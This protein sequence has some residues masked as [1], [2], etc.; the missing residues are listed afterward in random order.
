MA[1]AL[2]P[3]HIKTR[4]LIISDTHGT[5]PKPRDGPS[6]DDELNK[7]DVAR[8]VTGWRDPL[9]E[10]DVV[11]HCGDLT[12]R[13]TIPEFEATFSVLQSIKAPLKLAIAGNHDTA[14]DH[15][16]WIN[17][18]GGSKETLDNVETIIRKAEKDGV[19]YLTEGVHQF[20]MANGALLK[21]YASPWTP[22]Y[23]GWAFQY[24]NGHDFDIPPG[25]DVVLTHGPPQGIRDF[26]GVA[27]THAG[28]PDLLAA[29]AH[30]KPKI[31][32]FGH[33]HEAWGMHYVTWDG[34]KI[35][36]D[37]SRQVGLKGLRP[38]KVTQDDEMAKI[39]RAKLIE[40]SKQR[41]AYL[42]LTQEDSCIIPGEQT[43]FVNAAIMDIRYRPIQ[44]PWLIDVNLAPQGQ[45]N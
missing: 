29:V 17:K 19:K 2:G 31:H 27:G 30:A 3:K 21:V 45:K 26:A 10:V 35:N 38:G 14:L 18:F 15:D 36:E 9:P 41:G 23:G 1:E 28:C 11:I 13:T 22:A 12:K 43:L 40:M 16:Y 4:I 8:T 34:D 42:D 7:E 24:K 44:L 33:I 39:T 32:C 20:A 6:T 25:M 37:R 5:E